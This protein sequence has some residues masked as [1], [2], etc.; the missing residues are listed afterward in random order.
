VVDIAWCDQEPPE[1]ATPELDEELTDVEDDWIVDVEVVP[2][3]ALVVDAC[4]D[5]ATPGIV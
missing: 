3:E 4:V 5:D 2:A 1:T